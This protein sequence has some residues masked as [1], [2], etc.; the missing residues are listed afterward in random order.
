MVSVSEVS[1]GVFGKCV[2]ISNREIE[3]IATV[4]LGPRVIRFGAVG[5][6]NI[7]ME[8]SDFSINQDKNAALFAEKFGAEKGT[9]RIYGG[10]RLWTSPE[11]MPRSYYPE[12]ESV[13]YEILENGVKLMPKTQAWTQTRPEI[14][15]TMSDCGNS[16]HIVHRVYNEGAWDIT[17]SAW[18]MSVLSAGGKELIPMPQRKTGLLSNRLISLW[19]YTKMND[20]RV[21]WGDKYI[22]LCQDPSAERPFKFGIDSQHGWAAYFNHGDMFVKRFCPVPGGSYPDGGMSF[23]TYTNPFFLEMETLS[24]LKTVEPGGFTEHCEDWQLFKDVPRP[25][26]DE[27]EID[28]IVKKYIEN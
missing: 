21:Y 9:F 7:M 27:A 25:S 20:E 26:N 14:E 18:P 24:E 2:S 4:D 17:F 22:T 1:Y 10:H 15:I 16:V 12:N 19:D 3:L 28:A 8:N 6:E 23:E 5:G 11:A 13:P